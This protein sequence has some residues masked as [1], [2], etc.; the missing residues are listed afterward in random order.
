MKI[1]FLIFLLSSTLFSQDTL[2]IL[3]KTKGDLNKTGLMKETESLF[4][5][6]GFKV[7]AVYDS[8]VSIFEINM[9]NHP[10]FSSGSRPKATNFLMLWCRYFKRY[11]E[12]DLVMWESDMLHSNYNNES[13]LEDAVKKEM[14]YRIKLF[15]KEYLKKKK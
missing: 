10:V 5:K 2:Y 7:S 13:T 14:T 15:I 4:R 12:G 1:L 9:I 3:F 11:N 8:T 6:N